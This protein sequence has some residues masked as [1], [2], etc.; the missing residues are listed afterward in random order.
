[1]AYHAAK[2]KLISFT[3]HGAGISDVGWHQNSQLTWQSLVR[4]WSDPNRSSMHQAQSWF[5]ALKDSARSAF[6][7]RVTEEPPWVEGEIVPYSRTVTIISFVFLPLCSDPSCL[8]LLCRN[9]HP[10]QSVWYIR[11]WAA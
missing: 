1:M 9:C 5:E 8:R 7:K 4:V 11:Y 6:G 3:A 2:V 10:P